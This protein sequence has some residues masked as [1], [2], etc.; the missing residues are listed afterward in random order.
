MEEPYAG[1][2]AWVHGGVWRGR[3][4]GSHWVVVEER[5][6]PVWA[7]A[8]SAQWWEGLLGALY[9][10]M[11]P[12]AW[13]GWG[14]GDCEAALAEVAVGG[15]SGGEGCLVHRQEVHDE[16]HSPDCKSPPQ[17][18]CPPSEEED[19]G[20][21]VAQGADPAGGRAQERSGEGQG[22]GLGARGQVQGPLSAPQESR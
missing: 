15:Q 12:G 7:L 2:C 17:S 18:H 9:E 16:P 1:Q 22:G 8:R 21:A 6:A 20:P 19:G 13:G 5:A 11:G 4:H 14:A 10:V 3:G